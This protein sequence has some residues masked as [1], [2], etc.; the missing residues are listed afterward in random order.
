VE[1]KIMKKIV[2]SVASILLSA[3]LAASFTACNKNNS[4]SGDAGETTAGNS[5]KSSDATEA[6]AD[7]AEKIT[8]NVWHQWATDTDQQ[9]ALLEAAVA[10]YMEENPNV[11][12]NLQSLATEPYKTKMAAEFAGDA[13]GV[14]VF[15]YQGAGGAKKFVDAGKVLP[16]DDYLTDDVKS[17][18]LPG[19]TAAFEYDGKTYAVPINAWYM[20]L[21]CNQDIFDQAGAKLPTTYDELLDACKKISALDGITPIASGAKDGW[22]AGFDYQAIALREVGA[23]NINKMLRGEV[24]F[25]DPGYKAAADKVIELYNAGAFGANP[26]EAGNDDCNAAFVTGKAAMQFMGS[27]FASNPYTD[28]AT[29]INPDRIVA[30]K[31]PTIEGKGNPTDY[32][33]GFVDAFW[34]NKATKYP[35]QAVDFQ[36]YISEAMGKAIYENG[37]GLCGWNVQLDESKLT[38]LFIQIKGL[39]NEGT[40]SVLAWDTSL[41]SNT[42]AIHNEQ[43]QALLSP[44]ASSDDFVAEHQAALNG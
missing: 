10:K 12:I 6:P 42:A 31:I 16:I 29:T 22:R 35:E 23:E 7:S 20:A 2:K 24:G 37:I 18:I 40:A 26:L 21:F 25:D 34:V 17:K 39:L 11:T 38:P 44:G 32:C 19:S 36:I 1:G 27:W 3:S 14:D 41:D 8:L 43:A 4:S 28:P 5:E 15:F 9:K 33:G 30:L 13:E